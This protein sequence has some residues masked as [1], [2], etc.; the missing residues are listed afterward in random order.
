MGLFGTTKTKKITPAKRIEGQLQLPGDKSISH[1]YA[2]L[3]A[4]AEGTTEIHFFATSADCQSTLDCLK[5]LGARIERRE[6][7][8]II[9]GGGLSGLQAPKDA[10]DAGNSGSTMRML[11][12]ILAGQPFR[13]VITGDASLSRRPMKRVIEPLTQMGA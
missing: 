10:L 8:V 3:G 5:E 4:I 9:R 6:N 7:V 11:A 12:G 2:M 13:S 1:R